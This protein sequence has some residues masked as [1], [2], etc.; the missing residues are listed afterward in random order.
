ME[1]AGSEGRGE[2]GE[3]GG[4]GGGGRWQQPGHGSGHGGDD[5]E[6]VGSN[7]ED[8]SLSSS[9]STPLT[10]AID[11]PRGRST[12]A[13]GATGQPLRETGGVIIH[14]N[15]LF[16]GGQDV[17]ASPPASTSTSTTSTT[18]AAAAA[19]TTGVVHQDDELPSGVEEIVE[20]EEPGEEG[21]ERRRQQVPPVVHEL[22]T[23]STPASSSVSGAAADTPDD[24]N[25]DAGFGQTSASPPSIVD[26]S[27][28]SDT[29]A[30][31]LPPQTSGDSARV[32]E[33]HD[34]VPPAAVV[35]ELPGES[36][37]P[38]SPEPSPPSA[39][40]PASAAPLPAPL[41]A[42]VLCERA[43]KQTLRFLDTSG[44]AVVNFF[45]KENRHIAVVPIFI[46]VFVAG[47]WAG[48]EFS[49]PSSVVALPLSLHSCCVFLKF[50][51]VFFFTLP[52]LSTTLSLLS[53]TT[54]FRGTLSLR[55]FLPNGR[56]SSR[57]SLSHAACPAQ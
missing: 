56:S 34:L 22:V 19:A 47:F 42:V 49:S 36:S 46:S 20:E 3:G 45:S 23:G 54:S 51:F 27:P 17:T 50:I 57:R 16:L 18:T 2:T 15:P 10:A 6:V 39:G 41:P 33:G 25:L 30:P 32:G 31:A 44:V 29:T 8:L 14:E 48:M 55:G 35:P 5:W 13:G 28:V 40:V 12:P 53:S 52:S 4:G 24:D 7:G 43:W 21:T 11:S 38:T 26:E 1:Q 9:S 37:E